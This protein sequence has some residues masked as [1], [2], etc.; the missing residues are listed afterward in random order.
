MDTRYS[1]YFTLFTDDDR[2]LPFRYG[3][4]LG[5]RPEWLQRL[6]GRE[7]PMFGTECAGTWVMLVG[8]MANIANDTGAAT[9]EALCQELAERSLGWEAW[10]EYR[11]V[12][13]RYGAIR[14]KGDTVEI[15]HWRD[16]YQ[17]EKLFD[18]MVKE[19]PDA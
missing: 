14:V 6:K 16:L 4:G 8:A 3:S 15:L 13:V 19:T 12:F 5:W 10:T 2:Q 17:R 11:R 1:L 18:S 7:S 9:E